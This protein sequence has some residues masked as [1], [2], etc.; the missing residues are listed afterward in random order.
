M[1]LLNRPTTNAPAAAKTG[2]PLRI[3]MSDY[4]RTRPL[5]YGTVPIRGIEPSY[6]LFDIEQFCV[7]PVYEEFDVAEM[8]LSWYIMARDRGEP[9]LALPIFPLR[10]PVLSYVFCRADAPY[11]T[12]ADLRGKR[13]A[14]DG[15]RIT[16]NLWLR[17]IFAEHY[18][19][20]P[21]DFEWFSGFKEEGAGFVIPESVRVTN[22]AGVPDQLLLDGKVDAVFSP[23]TLPSFRAGN[24]LIRRLFD[25]HEAEYAEYYRKTNIIPITHVMV[26]SEKVLAREPWIAKALLDAFVAAQAKVDADYEQE[27]FLSLPLAIAAI[28]KQREL[29][30]EPLYTHGLEANRHIVDTFVRY[31]YEQGY[32]R[33]RLDLDK[34]FAPVSE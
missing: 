19:L 16:V 11:R 15:Y 14:T 17:G 28:E 21:H 25:D 20:A 24:P 32:I 23:I 31:G 5:V 3:A 7:R 26:V 6:S 30:G 18:G 33:S 10:M 29:V 13:V 22:D 2:L 4:D 9:V 12:P 1:E 8:S 27:K 34:I